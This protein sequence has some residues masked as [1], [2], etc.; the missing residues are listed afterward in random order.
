MTRGGPARRR[1]GH[2]AATA[3]R[4]TPR[5]RCCRRPACRSCT[6]SSRGCATP[7]S[8]T[9]CS[10]RRTAPRSS[11]T[12]SATARRSG[13]ASTTSHEDEP[14]GTGGGIRNVAGLLRERPRRPGRHPQRRRPVRPR[15]RASRSRRT[16][17]ADAD[18]TLHLTEVDD[19]RAFGCVPT[20]A[21]GP[22]DCVPREDARAG[23]QPDQRRLLRL[24]PV[25]DR[26][27]PGRPAGLGGAR[28]VP[29]PGGRRARSCSA[30]ST[31]P[32]GSTSARRR[33][34]CVG[35]AT[36]CSGVLR[37][38]G[39]AGAGRGV[40][41]AA[42]VRRSPPDAVVTGGTTVGAGAVVGAGAR[43]RRQR[44]CST[45]PSGRCRRDRARLG[46]RRGAPASA[47]GSCSTASCVGD[48][49]EIGDGN[50]LTAGARVWCDARS[51][52]TRSASPRTSRPLRRRAR[53]GCAGQAALG[54]GA[55][56]DGELLHERLDRAAADL[57]AELRRGCPARPS[58]TCRCAC[59]RGTCRRRRPT[60]TR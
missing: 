13:C 11:A 45:A 33:P 12:G 49:A 47:P 50:E 14:L 27:D 15:P 21:D 22:G 43:G 30:T 26:R 2:P 23:H 54:S 58:A 19:P 60:R 31:R 39:A 4:R 25:G 41:A 42:R 18:V 52:R 56:V 10:R 44:R 32:T 46:R 29:G 24:P 48:G 20:D 55:S 57:A 17:D 5:S 40:A 53:P 38:A 51:R 7:A 34:T 36:S 16:V 35:R 37:V 3:H 9:S 6:T 8:T 59:R 1:P 28:D